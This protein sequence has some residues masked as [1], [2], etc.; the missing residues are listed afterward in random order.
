MFSGAE[1]HANFFENSLIYFFAG[2]RAGVRLIQPRAF[3][4]RRVIRL[5]GVEDDVERQLSRSST[6]DPLLVPQGLH[7]VDA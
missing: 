1:K 2:F 7:G 6:Q 4:K 3:V 5:R